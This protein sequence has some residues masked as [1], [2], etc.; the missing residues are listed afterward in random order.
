MTASLTLTLQDG[1][2]QP[3][4][5]ARVT[6]LDSSM[7]PV[8][9]Y[10]RIDDGD[11]V[12]GLPQGQFYV[13]VEADGFYQTGP[14]LVS[15]ASGATQTAAP[16]MDVASLVT[17][18]VTISD[19]MTYWDPTAPLVDDATVTIV[20][21]YGNTVASET[22]VDGTAVFAGIQSGSY[23]LFVSALGHAGIVQTL[24]LGDTD[25]TQDTFL[26]QADVTYEMVTQPAGSAPEV[27]DFG[28]F[29]FFVARDGAL[30]F[31]QMVSALNLPNIL[32]RRGN[33]TITGSQGDDRID[34]RGGDDTVQGGPGDDTLRGGSGDDMLDGGIDDDILLGKTGNDTLRDGV[35][36]DRLTGGADADNFV[37]VADGDRDVV[38]DFELGVDTLRLEGTSY[39][40]LSITDM[41]N[42]NVRIAYGSEVL[43]L[44]DA[45][46][47][48]A[49]AD[50][51]ADNF[52]FF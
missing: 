52:D 41:S 49:A 47:T 36:E 19:E 11:T 39:G 34:G 5:D 33:E 38:T 50:L 31:S 9:T 14:L 10:Y 30:D 3:I 29:D 18:T 28:N 32:G 13:S 43:I 25:L 6:I 15:L 16:M 24:L 51:T 17:L 4:T 48:L 46:N 8:V 35:G 45:G 40:A 42:G 23:Q 37:L 26:Q 21:I 27:V 2:G 44:R 22:D 1:T 12:H 20:D 7:Q